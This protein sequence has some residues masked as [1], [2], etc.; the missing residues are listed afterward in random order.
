MSEVTFSYDENNQEKDSCELEQGYEIN[1][2]ALN[3]G[4]L[5]SVPYD[6]DDGD[7]EDS[8]ESYDHLPYPELARRYKTGENLSDEDID[9]IANMTLATL[10]ET[11]TFFGAENSQ[12]DEYEG[13]RGELIFD[14]IN[15]E[16]AILIGRHGKTLE[17]LQLMVA[18]IVNKKLGFKFPIVIDIE[19]YK[20]RRQRKL[21]EIAL[22][23]V[24]RAI[25]Q[26]RT[27]KLHPMS[28]HDRRII[29][30]TLRGHKKVSTHS[31]GVEPERR[32]VINLR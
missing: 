32:V 8:V 13:G 3:V 7:T 19:S 30:L 28:S 29:H 9:F 1:S 20:N 16:L 17:A 11:L 12:I 26:K 4:Y 24:N 31:E 10:K 21:E 27:V 2:E 14:V 18:T 5:I 23:A 25:K 15:P 6:E 22:N